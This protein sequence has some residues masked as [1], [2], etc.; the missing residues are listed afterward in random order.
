MQK[1][2]I[3]LA[4]KNNTHSMY[5]RAWGIFDNY[6]TFYHKGIYQLQEMDVVDF[7][8]F[9]SLGGLA[10]VT[11]ITY[12]SRVKH[13]LR[14]RGAQDFNDSVLLWLTLNGVTAQPD[15]WFQITLPVLERMLHALPLVHDDHYEVCM[16]TALLTLGFHGLFRLGE[17]ALLEHVITV[18]NVHIG[19][20]VATII[21]NSS[22]AN[23]ACMT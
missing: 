18:E 9:L 13:N 22:K 7:V 19:T 15:V 2:L 8:A 6:C 12:M 1:G 21:L 5:D 3:M 16:Y 4:H 17:L 11:I 14:I 23:C 20:D 10:L